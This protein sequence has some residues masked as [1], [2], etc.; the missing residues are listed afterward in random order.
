MFVDRPAYEVAAVASTP[1]LSAVQLHG[2]EP[3]EDLYVLD[4][5]WI[6]RAFRLGGESD[7]RA[8]R[9]YLSRAGELGRVPDAC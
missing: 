2:N 8:M 4:H 1:G 9:D 3:P 6:I 7:V 5:L